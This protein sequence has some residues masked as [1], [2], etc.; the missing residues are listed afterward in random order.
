MNSFRTTIIA[1]LACLGQTVAQ[2]QKDRPKK[3]FTGKLA[4]AQAMKASWYYNW[5]A[6]GESQPGIE[7]VPMLKG[8]SNADDKTLATIKAS[9]AKAVLVLNEPERKSQGNTTVQEA[10]D[11]WP[12]VQATGLR[13]GSPATSS[14]QGGM[15]W[16]EQFMEGAAKRNLRV[17][18]IAVHWYRSANANQFSQWLDQLHRKWGKP[19]WVTEFNASFTKGDKEGFASQS[20]RMLQ[21]HRAVER[22]AYMD[23]KPGTP[24][25][26]W[27]DEAKTE[28]SKLGIRLRDLQ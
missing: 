1:L 18:F 23:M 27:K 6:K 26:L 11:L 5:G 17:D 25:A 3:G 20:F 9:G 22:F 8:K 16:M 21:N 13:L 14:D 2:E 4:H 12:K 19:I 28:P 10:L 24:G 7:F 15:A